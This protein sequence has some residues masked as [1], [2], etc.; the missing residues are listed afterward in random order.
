MGRIVVLWGISMSFVGR[1]RLVLS[2]ICARCRRRY[3]ARGY[4]MIVTVILGSV[5]SAM[6][7]YPRRR[8]WMSKGSEKRRMYVIMAIH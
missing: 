6:K 2:V 4:M 5:R 1:L 7:S 3:L 8:R